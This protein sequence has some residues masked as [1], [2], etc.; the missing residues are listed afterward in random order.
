VSTERL[1]TLNEVADLLRVS[2]HTV[3]AW[4]RKGRLQPVRICRR[5]LFA[6]SSID[7]FIATTSTTH[8]EWTCQ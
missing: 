2:P 1:L 8:E 4:V 3:R 6:P 5:L 7:G